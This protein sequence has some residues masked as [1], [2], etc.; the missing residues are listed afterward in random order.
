MGTIRKSFKAANNY[1]L[2]LV[3]QMNINLERPVYLS[4]IIGFLFL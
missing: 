4:V 3:N 2:V 1:L